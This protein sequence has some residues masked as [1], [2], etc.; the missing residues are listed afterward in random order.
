MHLKELRYIL[1]IIKHLFKNC[2]E[3]LNDYTI[4]KWINKQIIEKCIQQTNS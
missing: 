1:L 4:A 3:F 2:K